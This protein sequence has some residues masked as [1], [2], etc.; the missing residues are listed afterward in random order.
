MKQIAIVM[1]AIVFVSMLAFV[2]AE[3]AEQTVDQ[4]TS[5]EINDEL[6]ESVSGFDIGMAKLGIWLTFNQEKKAE[7]EIKLAR[8]ELIRAKIAARNNDTEAMEKALDAHNRLIERIQ[9]RID[10]IDGKAT[11]AGIKDSATKLIGL[12]RAIEVHEARIA[13]LNEI[14]ASENLTEEQR[15]KVQARLEQAE[16]NTA[17]LKEV[18]AAKIERLKTR[19]MAVENLTEEE[20]DDEIQEIKDAKNLSAVKKMVAEVKAVRAEKAAEV[21]AQVIAKLEEKQNETGKDMSSAIGALAAVQQKLEEKSE[22]LQQR[23]EG[24]GK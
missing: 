9:S 14:L 7:K 12:E 19:I 16:N 24:R 17:H 5:D 11:K 13:K 10:A 3:E 8:L 1:L 15:A 20:A 21:I 6:N 22:Q 4:A 18:E 2:A 23:A